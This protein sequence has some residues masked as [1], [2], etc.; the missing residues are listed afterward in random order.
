MTCREAL[1]KLLT[2]DLRWKSHGYGKYT[3]GSCGSLMCVD[4][5][6]QDQPTTE[7]REPCSPSCPWRQAEEALA[8]ND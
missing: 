4:Y 3:C 8:S 7:R 1:A 2:R 6:D 5:G